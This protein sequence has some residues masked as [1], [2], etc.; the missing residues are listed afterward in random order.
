VVNGDSVCHWPAKLPNRHR[1][2]Q[3]HLAGRRLRYYWR[4]DCVDRDLLRSRTKPHAHT[5]S[6]TNC[7]TIAYA[8]VDTD[9]NA[10]DNA[11]ADAIDDA[12]ADSKSDTAAAPDSAPSPDAVVVG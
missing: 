8:D 2:Y 7:V 4:A 3:P 9:R 10:V 12:D 6:D 11:D 1:R 5:N